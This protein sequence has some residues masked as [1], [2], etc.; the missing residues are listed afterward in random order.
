MEAFRRIA[1][2]GTGLIGGSI[3][4]RAHDAGIDVIGCDP[5]PGT[6]EIASRLGLPFTADVGTAVIGRD[7]IVC[8][9]PLDAI[10]GGFDAIAASMDDGGVVTD[11]GSTKTDVLAAASS[12]AGRFIGGHPMAGTELS[13]LAAADP[14][15]FTD[16]PWVLCPPSTIL[17]EPLRSLVGFVTDVMRAKAIVIDAERHDETVALSSHIPHV[18][19]GALAGAAAASPMAPTVTALAAGSFRDGTRVAGTNPDRTVDMLLHN[20]QAVLD[21]WGGVAG[22]MDEVLEAVRDNE[23]E[24]LIDL[25]TGAATL[26]NAVVARAMTTRTRTF[27][28]GDGAAEL[29]YLRELGAVGGYVTGC[30]PSGLATTYTAETPA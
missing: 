10:R 1:V 19:A 25:F 5:D 26:R 17:I 20:R 11:V 30:V 6:A 21:Q 7:L 16:A 15:L 27:A 13:G 22:F 3:L 4:R 24:T 28:S 9:A 8:A 12:L 18:L 2:I 14:N 23:H 29:A